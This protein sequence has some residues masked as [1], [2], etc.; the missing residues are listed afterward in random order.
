M[1]CVQTELESSV[2][3][4]ILSEWKWISASVLGVHCAWEKFRAVRDLDKEG[5]VIEV[6]KEG[7]CDKCEEWCMQVRLGT[8]LVQSG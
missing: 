5:C 8:L 4:G 1:V 7:A 6:K 2:I 3:R